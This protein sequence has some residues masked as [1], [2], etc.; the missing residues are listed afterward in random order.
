MGVLY[1]FV[2]NGNPADF[3]FDV[4][5]GVS[6]GAINTGGMAGWDIGNEVEMVQW[7]SDVWT[8]LHTSD[9]Y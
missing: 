9:V 4:M 2:M 1:G 7:M 3:A 5:T 6:A 8:N